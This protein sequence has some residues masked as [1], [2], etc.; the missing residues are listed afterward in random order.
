[1]PFTCE[2]SKQ[3]QW[4]IYF[5]LLFTITHST[6]AHNTLIMCV[7]N[8]IK[9]EAWNGYALLNLCITHDRAWLSYVIDPQG[10]TAVIIFTRLRPCPDCSA[11]TYNR[12]P[13]PGYI[14]TA[15]DTLSR[16]PTSAFGRLYAEPAQEACEVNR[17]W[18]KLHYRSVAAW[19][20]LQGTLWVVRRVAGDLANGE[21]HCRG[22]W[23]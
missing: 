23:M 15:Y 10:R 3:C 7:S 12:Y 4:S 18:R 6:S 11:G 21:A 19:D 5:P 22:P 13:N 2:S 9:Y 14:K 8:I 20:V 1:M 16:R 17:I